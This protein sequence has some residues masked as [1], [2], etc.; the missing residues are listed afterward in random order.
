MIAVV[1]EAAQARRVGSRWPLEV[2]G[3]AVLAFLLYGGLRSELPVDDVL[4][5]TDNI[6]A[7]TYEWDSAHLLMQPAAV[8]WHRYLG[9]GAPARASQERF[10][11][12]CAALSV[13]LLYLLLLRLEVG[14]ARRLLLTALGALAFN[15]VLLATSGHF[16]LAVLPFLTISL[17]QGVLWE[18]GLRQA[19][20]EGRSGGDGRLAASAVFLGIAVAFLV[21]SL[22]AAPFL[23][24]A[25]TV[26]TWRAG[27]GWRPALRR[28]LLVGSL[29][30]G[31][32]FAILASGYWLSASGPPDAAGFSGFLLAKSELYA[33]NGGLPVTLSRAVFGILQNFVYLGDFGAMVRTWM[34]GDGALL[35]PE[36]GTLIGLLAVFAAALA[37]LGWAYLGGVLRLLRGDGLVV[38]WAFLLGAL[39]FAIPWNL[40]EADFYF[41]ITFPTVAILAAAPV[42]RRRQLLETALVVLVASTVL[43]GWA[44]PR[45]T[46][47]L[48]RYNAE[49]SSRLTER[50]LV[51][52]WSHW[53]G[54][55]SLLFM[56]LPEVWKLYPDKLFY[57]RD[58][59]E[60]VFPPLAR[61]LDRRLA[62][63]GRVY[64][65]QV[66]DGEAWN[67]PWP[68]M[69]PSGLTPE[70]WERFFRDRYTVVD[71][72]EVAEIPCWELLPKRRG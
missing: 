51:V 39:A 23:G 18:R 36:R 27:G 24:L 41:P 56:D 38:P 48:Q 45:R 67:A 2:L 64:L 20:E 66:L 68:R 26:V 30:G 9:L 33:G 43:L 22:L 6:A 25:A 70:R 46:Y 5:F 34:I 4:R 14:L 17:Y 49:L 8:L 69:R 65:F 57:D 32:A 47:P 42:S 37:L 55:P 71:R 3:V 15:Q 12:S 1:R 62:G 58:D 19:R 72:G 16:K 7:G 54:G 28:V 52:T 40:N 60:A 13:G 10:N 21:N 44:L 29:A 35:A 11:A 50:D 63:G 61:V 53:A 59:A 31:V